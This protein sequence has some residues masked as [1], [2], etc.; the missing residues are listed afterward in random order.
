MFVSPRPDLT[1]YIFTSRA[2]IHDHSHLSSI[3]ING[4]VHIA[5]GEYQRLACGASHRNEEEGR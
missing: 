5:G 2:M 1:W 3:S 4:S